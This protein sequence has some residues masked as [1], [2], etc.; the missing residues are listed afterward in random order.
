MLAKILIANDL[1]VIEEGINI[2]LEEYGLKHIHP[3]LLKF[4]DQE[5]LGVEEVK[6]IREHLNLKP[7]SASLKAV[8]LVSAQNLTLAAQNALLK[9]L[10]EPP[11]EALIIL[12]VDSDQAL[13]PTI[14][15][16]CQIEYLDQATQKGQA[17]KFTDQI[18][19]LENL[20]L[21]ER[22]LFIEKTEDKEQFLKELVKYYR[23]KMQQDPKLI[24]FIKELLQA[25]AWAKANVNKRAILEYLMLKLG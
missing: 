10:E 16:R 25:E 17:E 19:K 1:G 13:L 5:K 14:I 12:G 9:T 18:A 3:D 6:K 8:V 24:N 2:L 4:E 23:D 20:S 22:F 21:E 15:S 7:Y 11:G